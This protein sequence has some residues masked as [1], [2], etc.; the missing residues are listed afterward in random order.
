M[1]DLDTTFAA[2]GDE[3]RRAIITR[4]LDGE[5]RLSELAMPFEMTQTAVSK[6]V[7]VLR[8]AG[9][10]LVE[11]RGRTRYCRLNAVAL[12]GAADWLADYE[13]FWTTQVQNL[14]DHLDQEHST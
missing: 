8:D 7:R 6:H 13:V 10:V 3:T 14:S 4:L 11:K 12:K 2:L 5:T 9:L 1:T